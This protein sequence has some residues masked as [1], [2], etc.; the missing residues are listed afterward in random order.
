MRSSI[1]LVLLAASLWASTATAAT[2]YMDLYA[3]EARTFSM[4]TI[5]RVAVGSPSV[6][7]YKVL[8]DGSLLLIGVA[9]GVSNVSVWKRGGRKDTLE[10]TVS[11]LPVDRQLSVS[12]KLANL[13]QGLEVEQVGKYVV[14][15]GRVEPQFID[16]IKELTDEMPNSINMVRGDGFEVSE[17]V[18]MDVK[19]VEIGRQDLQR[20]GIRWDDQIGGPA[21]GVHSAATTNPIFGVY[22]SAENELPGQIS[23]ALENAN[24][25][26]DSY[27][28]Q[29]YF[30]IT[31]GIG[32]TIEA[33]AEVGDA[34]ILSAPRLVARSGEE[35]EFRSGGDYP[36]PVINQD[37]FID[38]TFREY[39]IIL[40]ILPV[41]SGDDIKASVEAEVSNIDLS[42]QV[43]GV[44]GVLVR[45]ALTTI[46]VKDQDTIVISG[47]VSGN[48]AKQTQKVPFLG[49]IP[50]LGKLFSSTEDRIDE[51]E[52]LIMVTPR[53]VDA[54][55]ESNQKLVERV[56]GEVESIRKDM[57]IDALLME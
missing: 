15:K 54:Q 47:L 37:G 38:V 49:D 34:R 44:P 57:E 40:N 14:F 3:G 21:Y 31:T 8:D 12:K 24:F 55:E 26:F 23:E 45:R 7:N 17:M 51:S 53:I 29:Q 2:R 41:V 35:A 42:T 18:R 11:S 43:N 16:I 28:T 22:S 13:F 10:V 33:L 50:I 46:N 52:V 19:I 5:T 20:L 4:G 9:E 39:G 48:L 1:V 27:D 36:I 25:N 56:R 30:G 6:L 32:S